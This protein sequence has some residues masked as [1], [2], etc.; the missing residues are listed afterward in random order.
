MKTE[1]LSEIE[2]QQYALN[3]SDCGKD[4]IAHIESC[5]ECAA[6]AENYRLMFTGIKQYPKPVF[7]FDISELVLAR[8]PK[9]KPAFALNSFFY[10]LFSV[11]LIG[12]GIPAYLFRE[13]LLKIFVGIVPMV[14]YLIIITAVAILIFQGIEIY[15]K[16]Q[17]QMQ[18]LNSF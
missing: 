16:Y 9:S 12:I 14:M 1:H 6:E 4:I 3:K 8:L 13:Y 11:V 7:D 10:F 2:I 18:S 5:E 15:R 17:K